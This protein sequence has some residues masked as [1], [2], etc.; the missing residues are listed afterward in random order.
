MLQVAARVATFLSEA[1]VL[2]PLTMELTNLLFSSTGESAKEEIDPAVVR[3]AVEAT[4]TLLSPMTPHLCEELWEMIGHNTPMD[5]VNWPEYDE[6]AAKEEEITIVLQVNG[7]V[8]SRIMIE[9][10]ASEDTLK[11]KALADANVLKF[12]EG[13]TI[14]KVIVVP[15]K[16]VNIVAT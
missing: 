13:K 3:E 2:S 4:L 10:G 7:K 5:K 1:S 8:R 14:R 16:L 6:E 15:N 11:E 12:S 9:P